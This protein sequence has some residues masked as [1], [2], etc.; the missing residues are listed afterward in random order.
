M[1]AGIAAGSVLASAA[2][3]A[4]IGLGDAALLE[5]GW[6]VP[7][8]IGGALALLGI[9]LRVAVRE[10]P[11]HEVLRERGQV[12][13]SPVRTVLRQHPHTVALVVASYIGGSTVFYGVVIFSQTYGT[14]AL[15]LSRTQLAPLL[16]VT[17]A[18]TIVG[19]FT[20][21]WWGDRIG[22]QRVVLISLG[23][24]LASLLPWTALMDS[25]DY[26]LIVGA[27]VLMGLVVGLNFRL[28]GTLYSRCFPPPVRYTGT[29]LAYNLGTVIGGS[30]SLIAAALLTSTGSVWAVVV[31]VTAT[32]GVS[33]FATRALRPLDAQVRA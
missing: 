25:G 18:A 3:V 13:R 5:W 23:A 4:V 7:F 9:A 6:R 32:V 30:G 20:A 14:V 17:S 19:A 29:G 12:E 22:H 8:L 11:A 15:G 28:L 27:H 26:T 2:L 10:S 1:A 31:Y 33:L 21:A 16:G 24:C